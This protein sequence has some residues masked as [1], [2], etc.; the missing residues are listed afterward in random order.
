M[1]NLVIL[2][3]TFLIVSPSYGDQTVI[4]NY[5]KARDTYFYD[6]LYK[7]GGR[8]LYCNT[9]FKTRGDR[10][11]VEHVYPAS[12]MKE[13]ADCPDET[14]DGC[15]K[16]SRRFNL[17]EADLHNLFPALRGINGDR[18]NYTFSIIGEDMNEA[19]YGNCDFEVDAKERR[20]EPR[21]G[22]RGEIARAI[23]YMHS[24]YGSPIDHELFELLVKWHWDD[25]VSAEEVRRNEVI[26]KIQGTRN[27]FIDNPESVT[28]LGPHE[29]ASDEQW[30][31]CRIKGN[32]SAKGRIYHL[33]GT[34]YYAQTVIDPD[35]GERWFCSEDEAKQAG[36]RRANP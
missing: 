35:K 6:E 10:F 28:A 7:D 17:M 20:V 34:R 36:W 25:E 11:S 22:A 8:T 24:E 18:S 12:W 14:R 13:T 15:R 26:F 9:R 33:P 31:E 32:I 16:N 19:A 23:F 29:G 3:F 4:E 21:P 30:E 5:T 27:S 2:A 1:K